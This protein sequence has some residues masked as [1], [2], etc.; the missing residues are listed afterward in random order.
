MHRDHL[1]SHFTDLFALC[2]S[3]LAAPAR[4]AGSLVGDVATR[5]HQPPT[6]IL[7]F[8]SLVS[9][10]SGDSTSVIAGVELM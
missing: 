9:C 4:Q 3:K 1:G 10:E 2:G 8:S 6:V 7:P 5:L